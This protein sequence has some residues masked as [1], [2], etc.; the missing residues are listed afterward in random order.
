MPDSILDK[1]I[2]VPQL[3]TP[4]IA[5]AMGKPTSPNLRPAPDAVSLRSQPADR[6]LDDDA[7]ELQV[8]DLPPLYSDEPESSSAPLLPSTQPSNVIPWH[9][10]DAKTGAKYYLDRRLDE[11]PR[12]LQSHVEYW[13]S[14]P[15]RPYVKVTGTHRESVDKNGKKETKTVTDFD[16][17]IELTPYLYLDATN[18]I[19]WRELRTVDNGEKTR[20]GTIFKA[21]APGSTQSI[22]VGGD[23]KPT[24]LEWCHMYCASHAGLKAFSLRRRVVGFDEAKAKKLIESLVRGTNY[25]GHLSITFPVKDELVEVYNECRTNRGR[26]TT[27]VQWVCM[28]TLLF[29]FTWP[30]LFFRTKRFE[31]VAA[32]WPFSRPKSYGGKEYVSLS[33]DQWYNLWG[34]ALS[35]AV[36]GKQQGTLDQHDLTAAE[37]AE[38]TFNTESASVN[39]ALNVLRAGV[40]AMNEVNRQF[41]WGGDC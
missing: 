29:I 14:V 23:A 35:K 31:V 11:D 36:L 26:L 16:I 7:P 22:E 9:S 38:P 18:R 39:G 30:Y 17:Q 19:S 12:L 41:G 24:L 10:E 15:P 6:F 13:A 3:T 32:D 4:L 34:R 40:N 28:L 8:D 1:E 21:R 20:R 27:W 2:L 5:A 37:G 33:E 25:R